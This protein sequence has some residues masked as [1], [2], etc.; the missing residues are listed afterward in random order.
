MVAFWKRRRPET[1]LGA[2]VADLPAAGRLAPCG[3]E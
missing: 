2:Q 3:G 1:I